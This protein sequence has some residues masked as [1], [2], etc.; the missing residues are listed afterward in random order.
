MIH[1]DTRVCLINDRVGNGIVASRFIPRGT[2]VWVQD[3]L[4]RIFDEREAANLPERERELLDTY[5]FIDNRGQSV[6]CWDNAKYV[7]HS[8]R[9]SCFSTAYNFEIAIRDIHPGEELTDDY[10]YL[11][12]R[13]PFEAVDEGTDRKIVYPDDLVTYHREWDELLRSCLPCIF[14]VEQ[15]LLPIIP[16]A[17]WKEFT[18]LENHPAHMRSVLECHYRPP[19]GNMDTVP[20]VS[21]QQ[22]TGT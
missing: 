21:C 14:K 2:I 15:P 12:L 9:P 10:G 22:G 17:V 18:L 5:S 7:N 16:D 4:D 11:N 3:G 6:L 20:G 13:A 8:F 19:S 1:P